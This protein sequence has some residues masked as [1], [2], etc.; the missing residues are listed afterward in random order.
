MSGIKSGAQGQLNG[1]TGDAGG[2]R[3]KKDSTSGRDLVPFFPDAE[4]VAQSEKQN[5]SS[6][7]KVKIS[8]TNGA[9]PS[10]RSLSA[11]VS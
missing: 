5:G 4:V 3:L 8:R 6:C 9:P 2:N 10:P 1:F 7:V 11:L